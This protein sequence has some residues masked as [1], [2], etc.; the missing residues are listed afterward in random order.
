MGSAERKKFSLKVICAALASMVMLSFSGGDKGAPTRKAAPAKK[1]ESKESTG[2]KK[3]GGQFDEAI[4]SIA[5]SL[6]GERFYDGLYRI[7]INIGFIECGGEFPVRLQMPA[8]NKGLN[9]FI[10]FLGAKVNCAGIPLPL[11]DLTKS[12]LGGGSQP[13]N[14]SPSGATKPLF[15]LKNQNGVL[16]VT[17]LGAVDIQPMYPLLPDILDSSSEILARLDA[18]VPVKMTAPKGATDSGQTTVKVTQF[19]GKFQAPGGQAF[20]RVMS[21]TVSASGYQKTVAGPHLLDTLNVSLNMDPLAVPHIDFSLAL[22]KAGDSVCKT[23]RAS[24]EGE[25]P[26]FFGFVEFVLGL[27]KNLDVKFVLQADMI[28]F[29]DN[30]PTPNPTTAQPVIP[31]Q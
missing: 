14:S 17:K 30:K 11:D 28:R 7:K 2:D 19:N 23:V 5:N 21:W 10:D 26:A 6:A 12:L 20:D 4:L 25:E 18:T 16:G 31:V 3:V 1:S 13:A 24:W 27:V 8:A 15:G 29:V 9:T 22:T